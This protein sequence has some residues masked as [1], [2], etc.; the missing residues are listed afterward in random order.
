MKY[1]NRPDL[2]NKTLV[3][4]L[5]VH[6]I[7]SVLI[8]VIPLNI[9][10]GSSLGQSAASIGS[11]L[12]LAPLFFL[13]LKRNGV[14][15]NTP[16]WFIAH[17]LLSLLGSL[18]ILVHIKL[19]NWFTP[20]G[21]VL[22]C[23]LILIYQGFYIRVILTKQFSLLFAQRAKTGG[24]QS[25]QFDKKLIEQIIEKKQDLLTQIDDSQNE[26]LFS[27]RLKDWLK[28]PLLSIQYQKLADKEAKLIGIK[29]SVNFVVAWSRRFHM[30]IASL[31]LIGLISHV[32]VMLFFAGYA[33]QGGDIEWWYITDWGR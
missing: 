13:F 2:S 19:G 30:F 18:F 12:L 23:L 17:V 25:A 7:I 21:F 15:T 8:F 33:A 4:L 14:K 28:H 5:S 9:S 32:I 20:P 31:F 6:V 10:P 3:I 26:A 11:L 29:Q 22:L 1:L 27:P 24:F 16:F